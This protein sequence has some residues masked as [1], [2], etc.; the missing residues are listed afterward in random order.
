[1]SAERP[2][3]PPEDM[4]MSIE[5]KLTP[6][7]VDEFC[8][9][10][11][12]LTESPSDPSEKAYYEQRWFYDVTSGNIVEITRFLSQKDGFDGHTINIYERPHKNPDGT[13]SQIHRHLDIDGLKP[14]HSK[15]R[16]RL[17]VFDPDTGNHVY[18]KDNASS[19]DAQ[20]TDAKLSEKVRQR[21][22][23]RQRELAQK[24]DNV[25]LSDM[26]PIDSNE[27]EFMAVLPLLHSL[28]LGDRVDD[29]QL[30]FRPIHLTGDE[31]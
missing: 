2:A 27:A 18:D 3:P 9:Q 19:Q 8:A 15:A 30:Q 16:I 17:N 26:P 24:R 13:L 4:P 25:H 10:I 28:E 12:R 7:T 21:I 20:S 23:Q 6:A 5:T 22:A 31:F 29:S 11:N 1:M 14:S